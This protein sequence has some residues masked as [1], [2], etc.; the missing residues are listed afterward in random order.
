MFGSGSCNGRLAGSSSF[1]SQ[2]ELGGPTKTMTSCKKALRS[3]RCKSLLL[4]S[5]P[6][7]GSSSLN[8][9][10][11][12]LS[13]LSVQPAPDPQLIGSFNCQ[14]LESKQ[15]P[16]KRTKCVKMKLFEQ[17]LERLFSPKAMKQLNQAIQK[18]VDERRT[19]EQHQQQQHRLSIGTVCKR[20]QRLRQ[21]LSSPASLIREF[22]LTEDANNNLNEQLMLNCLP[23]PI[24]NLLGEL[25]SRGPT[26]VGIFRKS[27][28][29]KHCK[30]LR[31][32]LEMDSQSCVG[33]FQVSVIASV[34]KVS[35][36]LAS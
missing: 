33:H 27:P 16:G 28:S 17:P 2:L 3:K 21:T 11:S 9:K 31:Q 23:E 1:S 36:E 5:S 30:E 29:A 6:F 18:Q 13:L 20:R 19:K 14:P 22:S 34:F 15:S 32:K 26:T 10:S 35:T 7:S 25:N 12:L 4:L 8:V 24:R